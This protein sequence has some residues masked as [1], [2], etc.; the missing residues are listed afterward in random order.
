MN[1]KYAESN[2]V[3]QRAEMSEKVWLKMCW[4]NFLVIS[5]LV[6][7]QMDNLHLFLY[8]QRDKRQTSVCTMS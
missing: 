8:Q 7:L 1:E 5:F 6:C 3:A 4:V 2:I